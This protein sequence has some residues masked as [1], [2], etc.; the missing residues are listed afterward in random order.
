MIAAFQE[1]DGYEPS[2]SIVCC[3]A[4]RRGRP[5]MFLSPQKLPPQVRQAMP[6]PSFQPQRQAMPAFQQQPQRQA[7]PPPSFQ[8][9]PQRQAMPPPSSQQQPRRQAMPMPSFQQ[10]QQ[11]QRQAMPPPSFQQPQRQ[12]MPPPSS[13]QPSA[14][15]QVEVNIMEKQVRRGQ[16]SLEIVAENSDEESNGSDHHSID[17]RDD[18][19][20]DNS[21]ADSSS[22]GSFTF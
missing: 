10:Q 13:Q 18:I 15:A 20:D 8:Q 2:R 4:A 9:Q 1:L 11:P 17:I 19:D 12:A 21:D 22:V 14:T 5:E 16:R 6:M 3:T 7:M